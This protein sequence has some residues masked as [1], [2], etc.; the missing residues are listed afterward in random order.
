MVYPVTIDP[1]LSLTAP[2]YTYIDSFSSNVS[3]FD[4]NNQS[5]TTTGIT[6]VG[7]SNGS[8]IDRAFYQFNTAPL[9]GATVTAATLS[10]REVGSGSC[11]PEEVDVWDAGNFTSASTWLSP[12][13]VNNEWA[14]TVAAA[15]Y[16]S[17][18][19]REP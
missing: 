13:T 19:P 7:S 6:I 5:G 4:N 2:N 14:S 18:C 8:V 3:F 12:P 9:A 16:S 15:G 11:T 1:G 17:A 10:L